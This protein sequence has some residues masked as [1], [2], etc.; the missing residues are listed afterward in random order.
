MKMNTITIL[1][2]Q[3]SVELKTLVKELEVWCC[4]WQMPLAF[5]ICVQK[6]A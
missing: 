3:S 5:Q 4:H 1:K 2:Q 6:P